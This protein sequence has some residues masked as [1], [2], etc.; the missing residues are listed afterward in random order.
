MDFFMVDLSVK[1]L[2][3]RDFVVQG[4][5]SLCVLA[6]G[7][8]WKSEV[9]TRSLFSSIPNFPITVEISKALTE[10]CLVSPSD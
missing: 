7:N 5:P 8:S 2:L 9:Q 4:S 1:P 3:N 10:D 6:M